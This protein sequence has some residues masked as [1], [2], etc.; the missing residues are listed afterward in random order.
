MGSRRYFAED[1]HKT[2]E[3]DMH[4]SPGGAVAEEGRRYQERGAEEYGRGLGG[5][6]IRL[7]WA[8]ERADAMWSIEYERFELEEHHGRLE[9]EGARSL[10]STSLAPQL[11]L[12]AEL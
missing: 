2:T 3:G 11:T 6:W 12:L 8:E 7:G 10:H 4:A 1:E 5:E 9:G